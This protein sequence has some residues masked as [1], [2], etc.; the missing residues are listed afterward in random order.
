MSGITLSRTNAALVLKAD[1]GKVELR[2]PSSA[3]L[4]IA[5]IVV[6][7][8]TDFGSDIK[9]VG[10]A[11]AA[12]TDSTAS[13]S[14]HVHAH[15]NQAGGSLHAVATDSVAGFI[16]AADKTK[17]DAITGT[18]TG[19]VTLGAVGSSPNA[20]AASLTGQVLT[21]QPADDS[22]PGVM[23]AADKTKLDAITGTNTGD[24]TLTAVGSAPNAD[25]ASLSGQA[26]TLQPADDTHPG[27]MSAADKTKL[28][29]FVNAYIGTS[30]YS[31]LPTASTHVG[32]LARLTD[33][34]R[35]LWQSN[36]TAW[37]PVDGGGFNVVNFGAVADSS[38]DNLAAFNAAIA[39]S[40]AAGAHPYSGD[41]IVPASPTG[42]YYVLSG[43]LHITR[44]LR[45]RGE[46]G[47]GS[48][49]FDSRPK[50]LFPAG[51]NG[52][53][54]DWAD[55]VSVNGIGAEID[56]LSLVSSHAP[57]W[58]PTTS[59]A[60]G[61]VVKPRNR[62]G[63]VYVNNG[64][65]G[66]TGSS[67][68]AWNTT[69]GGT[70]SDGGVTWTTTVAAGVQML[71]FASVH[72]CSF[73]NWS[74]N[75][76]HIEASVPDSNANSW[77]VKDCFIQGSGGSGIFT[78]GTDANGGYCLGCIFDGNEAYGINEISFLGN[79]YI[80]NEIS[81]NGW[82]TITR[83]R[84]FWEGNTAYSA[85]ERVIPS[86]RN[87]FVFR[88][89]S[90]GTTGGSEPT[91]PLVVGNTVVDGTVTW[92]CYAIYTGGSARLGTS[93]GPSANTAQGNY[94]E[95]GQYPV[96]VG[97]G[98]RWDAGANGSGVDTLSQGWSAY[99][100]LST[101]V[102]F[103]NV[104]GGPFFQL[105]L[106]TSYPLK[107]DINETF[108]NKGYSL[109]YSGGYWRWRN[110]DADIY[111]ALSFT[112]PD[113]KIHNGN[114]AAKNG[115]AA[116]EGTN[117]F[118]LGSDTRIFPSNDKPA[119][120]GALYGDIAIRNSFQGV[121]QTGG[122]AWINVDVTSSAEA[123]A[124][125]AGFLKEPI[126]K[127]SEYTLRTEDSGQVFSDFG[128]VS[129]VPFHLPTYADRGIA[130]YGWWADF[131]CEQDGVGLRIDAPDRADVIYLGNLVS[132]TN[133]YIETTKKGSTCRILF[134]RFAD[135]GINTIGTFFVMALSGEWSVG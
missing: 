32:A 37:V 81:S 73:Q 68:P 34:N 30:T 25:G 61:T 83:D 22:H 114:V 58:G 49:Q 8:Q 101:G 71:A 64:S 23:S 31:G 108:T 116:F 53:V 102:R 133:G 135:T 94:V 125:I 29:S 55:G 47:S 66:T 100:Y 99:G 75:G 67:E 7:R 40:G 17:L 1:S 60:N 2:E 109:G 97:E 86:A 110:Q 52:I 12:G 95:G 50:L 5:S 128:A 88:T 48:N 14:D 44:T 19:D 105:C 89:A 28:D 72:D 57:E 117:G 92:T 93:P 70:T 121:T 77:R 79:E 39:A 65:T 115:T 4:V 13:R 42:G 18:N 62:T 9:D 15:A 106:D 103:Q 41:V 123:W 84:A 76:I 111:T 90:G 43:P 120:T 87:G 124:K 104:A 33:F 69:I 91:W 132:S 6:V 96:E 36:G 126:A 20:D 63:Y 24:V 78:R 21:L 119:A 11:N 46:G 122:A 3:K 98:T 74:G 113:A 82:N 112:T 85:G 107:F 129:K 27:V 131:I 54:T 59:Q 35:G 10:A 56:H 26:L 38:T 80:G 45:L 118:Y 134:T 16:S 130:N 51:S 127:T